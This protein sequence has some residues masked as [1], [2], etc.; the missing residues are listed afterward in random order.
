[1]I[2]GRARPNEMELRS[3]AGSTH[4]MLVVAQRNSIALDDEY[5][6][7]DKTSDGYEALKRFYGKIS[8]R[9]KRAYKGEQQIFQRLS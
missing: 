8:K 3:I 5:E 9:H 1:M 2:S 4:G 7:P 6:Y